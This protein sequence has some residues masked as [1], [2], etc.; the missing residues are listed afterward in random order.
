MMSIFVINLKKDAYKK[1][2]I[3][4]HF[5]SSGVEDYEFIEAIYGI[6]LSKNDVDKVYN[7]DKTIQRYNRELLKTEIGC[8]LSHIECYKK[9]V[10]RNLPG[11]F[12]FEDDCKLNKDAPLVMKDIAHIYESRADEDIIVMLQHAEYA[13]SKVIEQMSNKKYTIHKS[14]FP[15]YASHAYYVTQV[16]AKNLIEDLLPIDH[17]LDAWEI[18][19]KKRLSRIIYNVYPYCVASRDYD[20][21]MSTIEKDRT[22]ILGLKPSS[23][24]VKKSIFS[25]LARFFRIKIRYIRYKLKGV[26][27]QDRTW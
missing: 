20:G 27:Y 21:S 3:K 17:T 26:K 5:D 24:T 23:L 11:A 6:E 2:Y 10:E 1:E 19:A 4:K 9:I 22:E 25:K 18:L 13:Q 12:I 7:K 14:L 16:A 15:I 8:A